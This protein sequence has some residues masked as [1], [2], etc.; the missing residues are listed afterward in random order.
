MTHTQAKVTVR[1]TD[2]G[3]DTHPTAL[4]SLRAH[5]AASQWCTEC[6]ERDVPTTVCRETGVRHVG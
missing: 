6:G 2:A 5:T 3:I 4:D 1:L